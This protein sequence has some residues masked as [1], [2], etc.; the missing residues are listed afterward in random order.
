[1]FG[2]FDYEDLNKANSNFAAPFLFLFLFTFTFVLANV[3]IAI[4][5]TSYGH[6]KEN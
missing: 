4:L 2:K 3:F 1:M 5:E 6:I